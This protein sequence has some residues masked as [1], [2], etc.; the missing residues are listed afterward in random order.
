MASSTRALDCIGGI[1][2]SGDHFGASLAV[3][4]L[5]CDGFTDLVVGSPLEDIN[6]QTDSG[7]VQLIYGGPSEGSATVKRASNLTQSNVR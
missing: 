4:D 6:G 3:A 1:A 7:Y 5:D 2:E